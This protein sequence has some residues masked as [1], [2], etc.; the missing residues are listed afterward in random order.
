MVRFT[1]QAQQNKF[2]GNQT[3]GAKVTLVVFT[4]DRASLVDQS[5]Q[6][7]PPIYVPLFVTMLIR[8]LDPFR[9]SFVTCRF[10]IYVQLFP[11]EC[12]RGCGPYRALLSRAAPRATPP[13]RAPRGSS[14]CKHKCRARW[15]PQPHLHATYVQRLGTLGP[16]A[17][18]GG[19][20]LDFLADAIGN[21]P[22]DAGTRLDPLMA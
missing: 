17:F 8:S 13:A 16:F 7:P 4:M 19:C 22:T 9:L 14:V 11:F 3:R 21:Q 20:F 18:F 10:L 15:R 1:L 6:C 5:L 2:L 12:K